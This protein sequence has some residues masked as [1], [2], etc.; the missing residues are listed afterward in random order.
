MATLKKTAIGWHQLVNP[1]LDFIVDRRPP[2]LR[3]GERVMKFWKEF[4]RLEKTSPYNTFDLSQCCLKFDVPWTGV[5]STQSKKKVIGKSGG[6]GR[7][8][9]TGKRMRESA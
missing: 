8:F 2:L 4:A 1:I 5:V 3:V 7:R 6:R 9:A